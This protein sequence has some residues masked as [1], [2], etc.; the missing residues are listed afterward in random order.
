MKTSHGIRIATTAII[1]SAAIALAGCSDGLSGLI[2]KKPI[3]EIEA[4]KRLEAVVR[5]SNWSEETVQRIKIIDLG[6]SADPA[7]TLPPIS[8]Y[9]LTVSVRAKA[10]AEI[11]ASSEKAGKGTDGWLN[12]VAERF[13]AKAAKTAAGKRA[14]IRIRKIAS[15]TCHD[16]IASGRYVPDGYSPSNALWVRM[17]E[18]KGTAM[19]PIA[20]RLVGNVA[21]VVMKGEV[22]DRIAKAR[23]EVGVKEIIESVAAG[24]IA[25]GY[26]NVYASSTGLNFL[27][28]TLASYAEGD[29]ARMLDADVRSAFETFQ[30]GVPFIAL[31]TMQ[32]RDAVGS[33]KARGVLDAFVMERQTFVNDEKRQGKWTF[34]PF[35][36]RHDNPLYAVAGASNEA[37][38]VLRMFA[39]HALGE[40][41]Q[42]LATRYGFNA[43][44]DYAAPYATPSGETLIGA[45]KLWKEKKDAGKPIL[46]VFV[47]DVSG[48]MGGAPIAQVRAALTAGAEFISPTTAVGVVTFSDRV[49]I[50]LQPKRFDLQ[51]KGRFLAAV[52]ELDDGG[53]TAMYDAIAVSLR[54]AREARTGAY[55]NAKQRLIVLSDGESGNGHDLGDL[56]E[57]I[58]GLQIPIYTIAYGKGANRTELTEVAGL[59]EAAALASNEARVAH[60]IGALL[61]AQL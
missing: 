8:E 14:G 55:S 4:A 2:T 54:M 30:V 23:G 38:E 27:A 31:T 25:M 10:V 37:K 44:N 39:K 12:E 45:Q 11:C 56:R 22:A 16:Y 57:V 6:A 58:R 21:G 61:N 59:A 33:P 32:M 15:G 35:G 48:S 42:T 49:T 13:N 18:A 24:E 26:T 20:E 19:E 53:G 51:H 50:V 3:S 1:V 52:E 60:S 46:A 29:E 7:R 17:I 9:P 34:V 47:V 41:S 40:E 43:D 28:T 36:V 5:D